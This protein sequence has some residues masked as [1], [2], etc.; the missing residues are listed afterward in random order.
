MRSKI[1]SILFDHMGLKLLSLTLAFVLWFVVMNVEDSLI[2][3][4]IYDIPVEMINGKVI[5]DAGGVYDVTEGETVNIVIRGP[6]SIIENLEAGNFVAK[7]D[8]SHL[9][10]TNSTNII[11]STNDTVS[12]AHARQIVITPLNE[13]VTV[14]IEEET[15]K[16]VP[17]KVITTGNVKSGH[18]LGSAAPTPN[19]IVIKGPESVLSNIVEA[20]A[21]VDVSNAEKDIA[22]IVRVGCIDGY[23]NAITKD[24][25][26]L[27]S[28]KV[29]VTIPVYKTKTVPVNVN[30]VG[31][32]AEGYGVRSINYEPTTVIITGE[33]EEL[34]KIRS[35]DIND[36][37][38]TDASEDLESNI[39]L[40]DYMPSNIYI[41]DE[42]T[43][44]AVNVD[45][46]SVVTK[47]LTLSTA[48]IKMV[49]QNNDYKY[50][51]VKPPLFKVKVT[52]F[53]E[54]MN[55]VS[56][57]TFNPHMSVQDLGPGE[58]EI[59]VVF[60]ESDKYE[61]SERYLVTVEIS[62]KQDSD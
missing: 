36:L 23:G 47:E 20:R 24:N 18:A 42:T 19:M 54:D 2:T 16:S 6:R 59:R 52:G 56:I 12:A 7:A 14:S 22:E 29:K 25:V 50:Q 44:I 17:V 49:N 1:K 3:K 5:I 15:E 34:S 39:A 31:N 11:V 8:L 13:Y 27:S 33:S 61:I 21:V 40:A 41:A 60:D 51:I 9:S 43:E 57:D 53:Q 37:S 35:I 4:T 26:S 30:T 45:I 58:H 46:E 55:N 28:E 32:P 38:V 48:A 62:E 10:V